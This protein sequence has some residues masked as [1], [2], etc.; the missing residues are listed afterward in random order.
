M[1]KRMMEFSF[2]F[3]LVTVV[4]TGVIYALLS[5]SLSGG[6]NFATAARLTESLLIGMTG[7]VVLAILVFSLY[8]LL[9]YR[10]RRH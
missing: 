7:T 3:V 5:H 9:R 8:A 1:K 10:K 6:P 2:Y 4:L